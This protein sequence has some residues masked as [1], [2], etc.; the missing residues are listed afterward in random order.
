P[1]GGESARPARGRSGSPRPTSDGPPAGGRRAGFGR[2]VAHGLDAAVAQV[3]DIGNR[4]RPRLG[5]LFQR[6]DA[7]RPSKDAEQVVEDFP[8]AAGGVAGVR[9]RVQVPDERAI[10][11]LFAGALLL[12]SDDRLEG[13]P[14]TASAGQVDDGGGAQPSG[15]VQEAWQVTNGLAIEARFVQASASETDQQVVGCVAAGGTT[16]RRGVLPA[17]ADGVAGKAGD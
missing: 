9:V 8:I 14:G 11:R 16:D 12:A 2:P 1:L 7:G 15:A 5:H 6:P 13:L 10:R 4:A 3:A 17:W